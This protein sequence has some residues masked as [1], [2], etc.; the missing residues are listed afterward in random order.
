MDNPLLFE[1]IG[2]SASVLIAISLMMK[3]L[4]RL[5]IL[6]GIGAIL[7]VVYG[8]LIKS[9]PVAFLNGLIVIINLYYLITM[10]QSK[11]FFTLMAV[12]PDDA[13]LHFF[14]KFHCKDIQKFF[15]SFSY[16][17][18]P[19]DLAFFVLRDTVPAGLIILRAAHGVG[20]VLLDYARK[21]YRDFKIGAFIFNDNADLLNN[22]GIIAL[23][24]SSDVPAHRQYLRR[25][26]FKQVREGHF[27]KALK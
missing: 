25:I 6:N 1:M 7:F 5:R 17:P 27:R 26:G 11:D 23:E 14:I 13:Y 8:I 4:I 15:P 16:T 12:T 2:Y 19:E 24:A 20:R 3:S 22:L 21:D 9:Y 18:N 10:L